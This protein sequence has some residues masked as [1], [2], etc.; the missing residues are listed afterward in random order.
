[1]FNLF[2]KNYK[3]LQEYQES[4]FTLEE[5]NKG[6]LIRV[7]GGLK[8]A[9][10][11]TEYPIKVGIAVPAK[12]ESDIHT[13]KNS[14]EGSLGEIWKENDNGTIVAVIIGMA[15]PRFIELLSYA[16][17]NT[18]FGSLHT[19]LKEKFSAEDVQMYVEQDSNWD[20]Y[21]SFLK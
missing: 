17:K 8:D 12:P 16:K 15:E 2:K 3:P 21:K 18:D 4:W 9:V 6:L 7:N 20:T 13:I 14:M 5:K 1:M 10:G 11:R 19:K